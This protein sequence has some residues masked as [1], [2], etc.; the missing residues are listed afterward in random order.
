MASH[1]IAA[2]AEVSRAGLAFLMIGI[3]S[4]GLPTIYS[5]ATQ[6]WTT[7]AGIHGPIVLATGLWLIARRRNEIKASIVPG[8][9]A[10][11]TPFLLVFLM[12][13]TAARAFDF[14]SIEVGAF[15][16]VLITIAYLYVGGRVLKL[17]WFPIFYLLFI[18]PMPGWFVDQVT[19]P[20]KAFVSWSAETIL[21]H[22]DYQIV[23]QGVTLFID[24]Y[25]LLVKDACA[26]LNSLFS[27]TAI[28]LFYIYLLHNMSWRY[29]LFLMLWVV[30]MAIVANI[31][32]VIILVLI[33]HYF[34]EEAAQ[35]F[36]HSSAGLLMFTV[37][38]LGIFLLDHLFIILKTKFL[39]KA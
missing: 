6:I 4:L 25:Q 39:A 12:L 34:G 21:A 13:Y 33:T 36:L 37:A 9:W 24:Q 18:I 22:F 11:A 27:L 10:L 38:L 20:L 31:V 7:E 3:L 1:S 8:Q 29:S 35:G 16:G 28:S 19:A 2:P 23:R 30:P 5:I 14:L 17:L 15:F 26:G 32:R